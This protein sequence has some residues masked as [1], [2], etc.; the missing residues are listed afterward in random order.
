MGQRVSPIIV[1][2]ISDLAFYKVNGEPEELKDIPR[3]K[4]RRLFKRF[5]GYLNEM[6]QF[7]TETVKKSGTS[8]IDMPF[9]KKYLLIPT[10]SGKIVFI[11]DDHTHAAFAW[12]LAQ[13]ARVIGKPAALVHID[14]HEDNYPQLKPFTRTAL[15]FLKD[16]ACHVWTDLEISNFIDFAINTLR[17]E[18]EGRI[19]DPGQVYFVL[20]RK[21]GRR[22]IWQSSF[23]DSDSPSR[24]MLVDG[25]F[26]SL[27]R[28]D[29]ALAGIRKVGRPVIADI[30]LDFFYCFYTPDGP[31]KAGDFLF[32]EALQRVIEVARQADLITIATSPGYFLVNDQEVET[33]RLL[34][35]IIG[36]L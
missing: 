7:W 8:L 31:R 29:E 23:Y 6:E 9:L 28:V 2:E 19:V 30:D 14:E 10:R 4:L 22:E 1:G 34:E 35:R 32:E 25:T 20:T 33:R 11:S 21:I 15:P 5:N 24:S 13:E 12:A 36:A 16:V 27:E 3:T 17:D 18:A 26:V